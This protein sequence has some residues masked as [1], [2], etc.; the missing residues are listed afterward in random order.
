MGAD[1]FADQGEELVA[2]QMSVVVVDLLET[3]DVDE[4]Q[5]EGA[6]RAMRAGELVG[7]LLEAE[8]P[9]PRSRQL[10]G[11]SQLEACRCLVPHALS[12]GPL[13]RCLFTIGCGRRPLARRRLS[14][15]ARLGSLSLRPPQRLLGAVVRP[16]VSILHSSPPASL[17]HDLAVHRVHRNCRETNL[18]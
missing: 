12:F 15:G 16:V 3:V 8:P 4:H 18:G 13:A 11:R 17:E 6:L 10:V 1:H 5:R 14:V 2:G 9:R 7:E